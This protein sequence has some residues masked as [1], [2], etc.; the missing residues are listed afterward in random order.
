MAPCN[1]QGISPDDEARLLGIISRL[2]Q[3]RCMRLFEAMSS[4][5][6]TE[7]VEDAILFVQIATRIGADNAQ[8][9]LNGLRAIT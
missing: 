3:D 8:Q 1:G 7:F 6:S 9:L 5:P 4:P 2:G